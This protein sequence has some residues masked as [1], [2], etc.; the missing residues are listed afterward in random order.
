VAKTYDVLT[1]LT[2][3]MVWDYWPVGMKRGIIRAHISLPAGV[4]MEKAEAPFNSGVLNI[5]ASREQRSPN[6]SEENSGE[7]VS[8]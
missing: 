7:G 8:Q 4:E 2:W 1:R 5:S 6:G 3:W